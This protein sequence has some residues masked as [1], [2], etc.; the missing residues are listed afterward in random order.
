MLFLTP[1]NRNS[2]AYIT[3]EIKFSSNLCPRAQGDGHF[4]MLGLCAVNF[5]EVVKLQSVLFQKTVVDLEGAH[6]DLKLGKR[7][8]IILRWTRG[9]INENCICHIVDDCIDDLLA[10]GGLSN[11]GIDSVYSVFIME[12]KKDDE[13][14]A[15]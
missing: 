10:I 8:I 5:D 15:L 6:A 11:S 14:S 9:T 3:Q 4:A 1:I 7:G 13:R 12:N 2:V